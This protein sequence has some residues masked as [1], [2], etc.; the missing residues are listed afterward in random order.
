[1]ESSERL[2]KL[3]ELASLPTA[4]SE[5]ISRTSGTSGQACLYMADF[6]MGIEAWQLEVEWQK[7]WQMRL[8]KE[9][10]KC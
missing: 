10:R 5:S 8:I 9:L 4:A 3:E 7:L 6:K 2:E 1:M